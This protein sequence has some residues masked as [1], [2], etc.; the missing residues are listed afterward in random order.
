MD[1]MRRA[2]LGGPS[3]DALPS[4]F[5]LFSLIFYFLSHKT[6]NIGISNCGP[7]YGDGECLQSKCICMEALQGCA[8]HQAK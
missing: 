1:S 3:C 8:S 4:S 6:S 7:T 2:G 5:F